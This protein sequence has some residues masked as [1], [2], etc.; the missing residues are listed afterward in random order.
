MEKSED[1]VRWSVRACVCAVDNRG[2]YHGR[3]VWRF[4]LLPC[5]CWPRWV[6]GRYRYIK[7]TT[8]LRSDL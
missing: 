5:V 7:R 1:M 6:C 2:V 3:Q 8:P 4:G